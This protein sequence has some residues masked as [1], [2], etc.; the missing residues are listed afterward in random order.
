MNTIEFEKIVGAP[1]VK[2]PIILESGLYD[3]KGG[4]IHADGGIIIGA[5]NVTLR[6]ATIYGCIRSRAEAR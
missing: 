6:N 4:V 2:E 5:G 3:A 1:H